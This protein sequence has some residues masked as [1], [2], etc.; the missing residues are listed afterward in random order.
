MAERFLRPDKD[1]LLLP[2]SAVWEKVFWKG[3]ELCQRA[4]KGSSTST[5]SPT[6]RNTGSS[7]SSATKFTT[8]SS[9]SRTMSKR[10]LRSATS[11]VKSAVRASSRRTIYRSTRNA[12]SASRTKSRRSSHMY[13]KHKLLHQW[14]IRPTNS[15]RLSRTFRTEDECEIEVMP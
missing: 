11:S 8:R 6:T 5:P 9:L 14:W 15:C 13:R 10:T 1:Q 2:R 3:S 4:P 12:R 7:A